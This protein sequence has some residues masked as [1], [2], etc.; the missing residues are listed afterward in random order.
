MSSDLA[1]IL[2]TSL[3]FAAFAYLVAVVVI[4]VHHI[5]SLRQTHVWRVARAG[6]AVAASGSV[7]YARDD[8]VVM[9]ITL[10]TLA[11]GVLTFT[12]SSRVLPDFSLPG[13]LFLSTTVLLTLVG[14]L[15]S[16]WFILTIPVS[17][18]TRASMLAG[19][20]LLVLTLPMALLR[21]FEQYEVLCRDI[22]RQPRTPRPVSPRTHYPKV[23]VHVPT[24]AEP[25]DVV[26]ATLDALSRLRYPNLEIL[27]IDNNTTDAALW[28]PVEAH[29]RHPGSHVRFF[30]LD[31][32]PG[33]KAGALNF[34][35]T[36]TSLDAEIIGVVDADYQAEPDWLSALIGYFDDP[37]LGFVQP[38]H[39][40]RAWQANRFQRMCNWEYAT[41]FHTIMPSRNEHRAAITVGTMCLI[42]RQALEEAGGW[43]EWCVTEDSELAPR[44]HTLGYHSAYV[45]EVFGRGL[46][47]ETF[48]GY[49]KQRI[50]WTYG[51]VQELKHHWRLYLP[52]R[53]ATPSALTPIQ[54][55]LHFNRG[56]DHVKTALGFM[57][58]TLGAAT[59]V[60]M[61][62]HSE[63]VPVPFALWLAVTVLLVAGITLRWLIHR[64]VLG[65]SVWD[66]LGSTLATTALA[67]AVTMTSIQGVIT[68]QIPWRR[69]SKFK[70]F[71]LGFGALSA[72]RTELVIGGALVLG[73]VMIW[74]AAAPQG[75][76]L[77]LVI[78]A[79]MQGLAYL[80]APTVAL[81][82]DWEL[83]RQPA[84]SVSLQ[85]LAQ[86]TTITA[87]RH[88]KS[89]ED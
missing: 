59:I 71:S 83:R 50:R 41:F 81:M 15:W 70:A 20:P 29:C 40:Y 9:T 42:R 18:M 78:G 48:A 64:V 85:R 10:V 4:I 27:V 47:P 13:R 45:N 24:H 8:P 77:M 63:S 35:L 3:I 88:L 53:W 51:P 66:M 46:I 60:S 57:L 84:P 6:V 36:Q 17:G 33:A 56:F 54:K 38:P 19:Y 82:A 11:L 76:L 2:S 39:A 32:W 14:L 80:A 49:K 62:V 55:L 65:C 26:I 23:L 75:M 61:L 37:G 74:T 12:R 7:V 25:P 58:R 44:I 22:W 89:S 34:A 87:T 16:G 67:H 73:A 68:R 86:F 30:H 21:V 5:S 1:S 28:Q 79:I 72:A 69:T 52:R 43:S 31:D